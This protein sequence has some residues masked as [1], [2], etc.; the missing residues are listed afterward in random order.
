MKIRYFLP[1]LVLGGVLVAVG[2]G[3][4]DNNV[5]GLPENVASISQVERGR[6]LV[7]SGGCSDCH[8][9]GVADPGRAGW[10]SG[11][12]PGTPGQPFEIG[13]F[14][15]YPANLTPDVTY[16]LGGFT[17]LQIFNALRHGLDPE[18]TPSVVITSANFPT[19]PHYLAPPMPWPAIRHFSDEDIWAIVA[20]LKHGV[21]ANNNNVPASSGPPDH[22]A[23][24]Y[25]DAA[26]GPKTIPTYP[27]A[28]EVF[29]P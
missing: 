27:A 15:T 19:T 10:L 1:A 6:A 24:S 7:I 26:V 11:Y 23:S 28:G 21:K 5:N 9:G 2:C 8:N 16:G 12:H 17:D 18:D 4:S 20:Y 3:S 14:M 22:W 13:P 29:N 25:T